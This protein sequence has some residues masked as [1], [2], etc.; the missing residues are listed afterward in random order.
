MTRPLDQIAPPSGLAPPEFRGSGF[1]FDIMRFCIHDGPG[2][3]TAV[4]LKGCPLNCSWC[5][6]PEGKAKG[7]ELSYREDRC[8]HCG[9]CFELCPNG[10]VKDTGGA[11]VPDRSACQV[12]GRCTDT[13]YAEARQIVGHEMT[14]REVTE[15]VLKDRAFFEKSG[16]GVTFTGGEPILQSDFLESLLHALRNEGI[17]TAVETTGYCSREV[18]MRIASST[19]LFLYDLKLMDPEQHRS[20]TGVSNERIL[21]NLVALSR[22][23]RE[24]IVR[25]PIIP[26]INDHEANLSATMEFLTT[27]TR[28]RDIHLLPFHKIGGDKSLRLGRESSMPDFAGPNTAD[29]NS[30]SAF[31]QQGGLHVSIGG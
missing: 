16:G 6:N 26:G 31:F 15:E 14:T 20:F 18:M 25:M 9:D 13:C 12:C 21:E 23:G 11:F 22:E 10:A 7:P 24:V 8:V 3:R 1:V 4:F 27:R 28:L 19:D 29:L 17:H 5:H 2:I 30:I